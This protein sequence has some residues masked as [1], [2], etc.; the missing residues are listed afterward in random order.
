MQGTY[1]FLVMILAGS[2]AALKQAFGQEP[3]RI[4]NDVL[5]ESLTAYKNNNQPVPTHRYDG[6]PNLAFLDKP[7]V[8]C[9]LKVGA[10][11]LYYGSNNRC[12][13]V[14]Y[15]QQRQNDYA[16]LTVHYKRVSFLHDRLFNLEY[17]M[18]HNGYSCADSECGKLGLREA[19]VAKFGQPSSNYRKNNS[20]TG[21]GTIRGETLIWKNGV[22][23]IVLK[24]YVGDLDSSAVYFS[25]DELQKEVDQKQQK[26]ADKITQI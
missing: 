1:Y 25:L 8:D 22:S 21:G 10:E 11:G 5:G 2:F 17:A 15:S 16:D 7:V 20:K 4:K 19:L 14:P 12:S 24:E 18:H 9:T 3:Y 6:Q 23:T 26:A 13:I